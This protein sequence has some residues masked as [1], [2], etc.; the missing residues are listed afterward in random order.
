MKADAL[1]L[2]SPLDLRDGGAE[3]TAYVIHTRKCAQQ[4]HNARPRA[5]VG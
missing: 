5:D 2:H 1:V 4:A 3:E